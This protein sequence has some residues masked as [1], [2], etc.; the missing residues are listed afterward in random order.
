MRDA[1]ERALREALSEAVRIGLQDLRSAVLA[2][3]AGWAR[4]GFLAR[5]P[6]VRVVQD[7]FREEAGRRLAEVDFFPGV[8]VAEAKAAAARLCQV[9][10]S[11]RADFS[12]T[13]DV[14][15]RRRRVR[16]RVTLQD[17]EGKPC[18]V[19]GAAVFELDTVV[20]PELVEG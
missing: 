9:P 8:E 4:D 7:R 10:V 14:L 18:P 20:P 12:W 5:V 19:G 6:A 2:Q 15:D 3:P 11:V 16:A 13:E 1:V 17:A